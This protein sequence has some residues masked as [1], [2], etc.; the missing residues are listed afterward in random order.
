M[1]LNNNIQCK[2]NKF[3]KLKFG[4]FFFLLCFSVILN[5]LLSEYNFIVRVV[6]ICS[7]IILAF[8][9]VLN[10][11]NGKKFLIFFKESKLEMR[12]VVWPKKQ[13]T[14]QTTF[15][16]FLFTSVMTFVIWIIDTIFIN[17]ISFVINLRL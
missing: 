15:V 11:K 6:L 8:I 12:K 14:L 4:L 16:V 7:I 5:D 9:I 2:K 10:T 17:F 13:E 1:I 3:D